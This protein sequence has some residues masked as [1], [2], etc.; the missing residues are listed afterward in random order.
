M[1]DDKGYGYYS[2]TDAASEFN[3]MAFIVKQMLGA[4][5]TAT[6]VKVKAVTNAGNIS[7]VGFVDVLPLVKMIDGIGQSSSH[8]TIHNLPYLRIQGGANAVIM[9]PEVDDL[10]LAVFADRDISAVK[11]NKDESVPGSWRRYDMAD[12]IYLGGVLNGA[13]TQY[14]RFFSGGITIHDANG[15]NIL[16]SSSSLDI[17]YKNNSARILMTGGTIQMIGNI[18]ITGSVAANGVNIGSNHSHS[19]VTTGSSNTGPPV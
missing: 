11:V 14:V 15:N 1:S 9:D 3:Q 10:G 2:P 16:M 13:P 17:N 12:G 19:G 4:M 7:P 18:T 5:R 6:L 8:E